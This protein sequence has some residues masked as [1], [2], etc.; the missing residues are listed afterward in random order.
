MIE[1]A[2]LGQLIDLLQSIRNRCDIAQ[3]LILFKDSAPELTA[4]L[5]T[6]LEDLAEDSQLVVLRYCVKD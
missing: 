2:E 1:D 5:P 3:H 6:I 4:T